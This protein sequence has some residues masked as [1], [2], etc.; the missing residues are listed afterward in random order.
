MS[1]ESKA[2]KKWVPLEEVQKLESL[3]AYHQKAFGLLWNQNRKK[4]EQIAEANKILDDF[5]PTYRFEPPTACNGYDTLSEPY[6]N[7]EAQQNWL[8]RL[9]EVLK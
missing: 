4:T 3:V 8:L 2:S 9:R 1:P 6:F 7:S 5:P